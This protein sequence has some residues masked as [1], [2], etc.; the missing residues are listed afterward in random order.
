MKNKILA[1]AKAK[2]LMRGIVQSNMLSQKIKNY[3]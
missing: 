2:V 1:V 3:R